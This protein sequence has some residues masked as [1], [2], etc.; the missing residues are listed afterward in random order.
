[1]IQLLHK[2]KHISINQLLKTRPILTNIRDQKYALLHKH[3]FILSS[4]VTNLLDQQFEISKD[5]NNA[6]IVAQ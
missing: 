1:M 6:A 2:F 4:S 5:L 3:I